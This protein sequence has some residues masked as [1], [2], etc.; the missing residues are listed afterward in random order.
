M[1]SKLMMLAAFAGIAS[2]IF[3]LSWTYH[4]VLWLHFGLAGAL[5]SVAKRRYWDYRCEF[6]WKE[7]GYVMAGFVL[8]LIVWTIYIKR[9][10][11]WD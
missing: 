2:G 5:Y 6:K 9:K 4:F 7:R 8:F 10:G 3:F 1:K 11:A